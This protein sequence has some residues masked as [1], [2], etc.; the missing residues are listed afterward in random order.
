[1]PSTEIVPVAEAAARAAA[2]YV[3]NE[4][5]NKGAH[6]GWDAGWAAALADVGLASPASASGVRKPQAL[7]SD[8][9]CLRPNGIAED[10][11][12]EMNVAWAELFAS[13]EARRAKKKQRT[14]DGSE[15]RDRVALDLGGTVLEARVKQA[16]KFYGV[17][18]KAILETEAEM[19]ATFDDLVAREEAQLWPVMSIRDGEAP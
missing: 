12:L 16:R 2:A 19:T 15:I 5:Y 18:A 9:E 13:G 17:S 10:A 8:E 3:W 6:D 4:S 1:M 7:P 11:C 14:E